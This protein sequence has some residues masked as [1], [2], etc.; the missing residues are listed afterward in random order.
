MLH[1][2]GSRLLFSTDLR[3]C[4]GIWQVI[5]T[6]DALRSRDLLALPSVTSTAQG[7]PASGKTGGIPQPPLLPS[8]SV[9]GAGA[10]RLLCAPALPLVIPV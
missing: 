4:L 6:T 8:R 7:E 5:F 9:M 10:Q 1:F 3:P 2:R